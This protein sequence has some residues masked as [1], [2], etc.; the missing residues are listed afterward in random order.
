MFDLDLCEVE[1]RRGQIPISCQR[2][3]VVSPIDSHEAYPLVPHETSFPTHDVSSVSEHASSGSLL[4][5]VA[6]QG[7]SDAS[8]SWHDD[9][10]ADEVRAGRDAEGGAQRKEG[11]GGWRSK[12][13]ERE[14][15]IVGKL[16]GMIGRL[17][18]S[19]VAPPRKGQDPFSKS[20]DEMSSSGAGMAAKGV[21]PIPWSVS[22]LSAGYGGYA[23]SL[24]SGHSGYARSK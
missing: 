20:I 17:R 24:F 3:F 15:Q 7:L 22:R 23:Y 19:V 18:G 12:L 4:L 21:L 10:H 8:S 6:D 2:G 13:V 5:I 1:E 14:E 16:R 11:A 9:G